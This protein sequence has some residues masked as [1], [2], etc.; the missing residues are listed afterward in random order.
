MSAKMRR[1]QWGEVLFGRRSPSAMSQMEVRGERWR[2]RREIEQWAMTAARMGTSERG[3]R[4]CGV[5]GWLE[6]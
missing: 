5:L 6:S 2:H 1:P 3:R 4:K